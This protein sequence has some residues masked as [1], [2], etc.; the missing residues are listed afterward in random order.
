MYEK[1]IFTKIFQSPYFWDVLSDDAARNILMSK[2]Q[3]TWFIR[4]RAET[5]IIVITSF[6]FVN[7]D[8][9]DQN[10]IFADSEVSKANKLV[11]YY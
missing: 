10:F 5:S 1:N 4:I 3:R 11:T 2:P 9:V 7:G 8:V 6:N